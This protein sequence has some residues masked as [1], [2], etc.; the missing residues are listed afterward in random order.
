MLKGEHHKMKQRRP[1]CERECTAYVLNELFHLFCRFADRLCHVMEL[2]GFEF[3]PEKKHGRPQEGN[4]GSHGSEVKYPKSRCARSG[5]LLSV[6]KVKNEPS[7][8][9]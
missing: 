8:F 6:T 2:P 7:E 9:I 4:V 5:R 1:M 3:M